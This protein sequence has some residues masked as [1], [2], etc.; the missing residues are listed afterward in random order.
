MVAYPRNHQVAKVERRSVYP[1]EYVPFAEHWDW[2]I[3][4][5]EAIEAAVRIDNSPLF[6]VCVCGVH[7]GEG[8]DIRMAGS[9]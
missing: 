3:F 2:C 1:D 9:E 8:L 7:G 5:M 4:K 6:C